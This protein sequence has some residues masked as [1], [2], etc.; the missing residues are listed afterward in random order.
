MA[1]KRSHVGSVRQLPSG[2]WRAQVQRG[3]A[4]DGRRRVLSETCDT[5]EEA[6]LAAQRLAAELGDSPTL[7]RGVTLADVWATYAATKGRRLA[8]KTMRGYTWYMERVWLPLLGER[9]VSRISRRDVQ[10]AMLAMGRDKADRSRRILSG[11][12]TFAAERGA[13]E[14][15]PLVGARLE[16][17]GD[18]GERWVDESAFDADPFAAIE[19]SRDVWDARTVMDVLPLMRG[20]PLEAAWLAIVGGGLRVEEALAVR[21]MDVRRIE[22][23]G[24]EV[25]QIAVHHARTDATSVCKRSDIR[26]HHAVG[27]LRSQT[28]PLN[29]VLRGSI[30]ER[31][32]RAEYLLAIRIE[33]AHVRRKAE[34]F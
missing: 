2:R 27:H 5:E 10:E 13:I 29:P 18:T 3:Y 19:G 24:R 28:L 8:R 14:R 6:C 23:A 34:V 21:R 22:V 16:L 4:M 33:S 32:S 31:G 11:V 1:T 7:A 30:H 26:L 25:T 20:L 12:L 9:D 17:P 15:N